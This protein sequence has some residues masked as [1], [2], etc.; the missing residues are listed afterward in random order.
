[1]QLPAVI[2]F[3]GFNKIIQAGLRIPRKQK[4]GGGKASS[5]EETSGVQLLCT[6]SNLRESS[7]PGVWIHTFVI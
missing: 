3:S 2:A 5:L 6:L 1:M 7:G 4:K